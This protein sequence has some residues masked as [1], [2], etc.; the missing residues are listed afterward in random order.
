MYKQILPREHLQREE[1]SR[2]KKRERKSMREREGR[3]KGKKTEKDT[4]RQD[5]PK[6]GKMQAKEEEKEP[7][8]KEVALLS[9]V[10][11]HESEQKERGKK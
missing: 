8:V 5:G 9:K 2:G 11:Y 4:I 6:G 7:E 1:L 3:N 10:T